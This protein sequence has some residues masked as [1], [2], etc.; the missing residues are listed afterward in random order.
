MILMIFI[1]G[2]EMHVCI[3]CA[4]MHICVCMHACVCMHTWMCEY[5][6]HVCACMCT[7]AYMYFWQYP[8]PPQVLKL[9]ALGLPPPPIL[10][11]FLRLCIYDIVWMCGPNSPPFQRFQVYDKP[12]FSKKKY[13]TDPVFYH[14]YING[15]IF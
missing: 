13:L 11:S 12:P 14:C 10:K 3:C 9:A 6:T 5:L 4:C 8:L 1:S 2:C 7:H 15:P